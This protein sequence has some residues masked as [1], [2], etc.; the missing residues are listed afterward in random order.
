MREGRRLLP[1]AP[2][3]LRVV[4]GAF[5]AAGVE[6][7][8]ERIEY[9]PGDRVAQSHA[10]KDSRRGPENQDPCSRLNKHTNRIW[11]GGHPP[12]WCHTRMTVATAGIGSRHKPA[13]K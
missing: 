8:R 13:G 11:R 9:G 6:S 1:E 3:A 2:A 12:R 10:G 4:V 5:S 7:L